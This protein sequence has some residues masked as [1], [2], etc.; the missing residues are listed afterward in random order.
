MLITG[1]NVV[2]IAMILK[3]PL[4]SEIIEISNP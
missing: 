2:L 4:L 1:C 3:S